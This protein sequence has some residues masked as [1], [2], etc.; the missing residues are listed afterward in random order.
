MSSISQIEAAE[1]RLDA[2]A[3]RLA[4]CRTLDEC[5]SLLSA[6]RKLKASMIAANTAQREAAAT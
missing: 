4:P 6:L 2:L 3:S 5:N 1:C